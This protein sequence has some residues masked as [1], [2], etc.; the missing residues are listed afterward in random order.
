MKTCRLLK[1]MDLLSGLQSV[2]A[3]D[4]SCFISQ[5]GTDN[6]TMEYAIIW[7]LSFVA[8]F[9]Y[10]Y[11]YPALLIGM[12]QNYYNVMATLQ[13]GD[14]SH[15]TLAFHFI[16]EWKSTYHSISINK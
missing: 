4:E 15:G 7:S 11:W 10:S 2:I 13:I 5:N 16:S 3:S 12:L 8:V 6:I 9:D 1:S 14:T